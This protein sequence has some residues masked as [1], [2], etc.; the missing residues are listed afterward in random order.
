MA[1]NF[2]GKIS[3]RENFMMALRGEVPEYYCD[4]NNYTGP[5]VFDPIMRSGKPRIPNA[6]SVDEWGVT[7]RWIPGAPAANPHITEENKVIKDITKWDKYLTDIPMPSKKDLDWTE[8]EEGAKN[9][10]RENHIFCG[11]C[12][13]GLFEMSHYLMGFEDALI[14]YVEEPEAMGELLDVITDYKLEYVKMLVEHGNIDM[15]HFHD[16]WGNK[17]SLFLNPTTWRKILKPRYEKIYGYLREQGV[18]IQHHADCV[19]Q[20]VIEDM[21]EL[22]INVWHGCIPQNDIEKMQKLY[23]GKIAFQGGIDGAAIDHKGIDRATVRNEVRR[24]IDT[25]GPNGGFIPLAIQVNRDE[26]A[27]TREEID[28]YGEELWQAKQK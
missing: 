24:A 15:I 3:P 27:M 26:W 9:F 10:D 5:W 17:K 4:D 1:F 28:I 11:Y 25:Y 23:R 12:F 14:N 7:W 2:E 13:G 20:D 19:C 22:G 6:D 8:Y 16:D 18:I 21:I